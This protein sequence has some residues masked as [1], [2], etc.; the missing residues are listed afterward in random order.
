LTE[1]QQNKASVFWGLNVTESTYEACVV[2]SHDSAVSIFKKYV[3]S[4]AEMS[5]VDFINMIDRDVAGR[6]RVT[7]MVFADR[8]V[9][10]YPFDIPPVNENQIASVIASQ[11]EIHLPLPIGQM[12]YHW[13]VLDTTSRIITVSVA[14]A[15]KEMLGDAVHP[16][17]NAHAD[18]IV[19]HSEALLSGIGFLCDN[20]PGDFCLLYL[21]DAGTKLLFIQND[22]LAKAVTFDCDLS[23]AEEPLSEIL[24]LCQDIQNSIAGFT[25]DEPL[26]LYYYSDAP[27]SICGTI[28]RLLKD[29]GIETSRLSVRDSHTC[30][31]AA[32]GAALIAARKQPHY[33][34][35]KDIYSNRR[36]ET[37]EN[38]NKKNVFLAIA[39]CV[40]LV[41]LAIVSYG[42]DQHR[43][44]EYN[45]QLNTPE[46]KKLQETH[47]LRTIIAPQR[48]D[49][50]GLIDKINQSLP[51]GV[52][53]S[54]LTVERGRP[55][56][57]GGYC[58][59][60][61]LMYQFEEAMAKHSGVSM[62]RVTGRG[63]DEKKKQTLFTLTF[64]YKDFTRK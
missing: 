6:V 32:L 11:A 4:K 7:A 2:Q 25:V 19:L 28:E 48:I 10:F 62:V 57:V 20:P 42:A 39:A 22:M 8:C 14:A 33:D 30:S 1:I 56:T 21:G 54:S 37:P 3:V 31:T 51:G 64:D 55:I 18:L 61:K 52:T 29:R 13:R 26:P 63:L 9:G 38:S 44:A 41:V 34:L 45:R 60:P 17:R 53:V 16:A 40:L 49:V 35:F 27:E 15:K 47:H 5:W 36:T 43:L 23:P 12:L 58:K 50:P 46:F 59:D 24:L